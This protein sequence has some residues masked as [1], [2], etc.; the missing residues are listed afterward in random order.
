MIGRISEIFLSIQGEGIRAGEPM[1]FVRFT[2]CNLSCNYCDTPSCRHVIAGT[3]FTS[4]EVIA[5]IE[6]HL[7]KN[8]KVTTIAFTGGEPLL[9]SEFIAEII[10]YF[11]G[12]GIKSYIDTNGTLCEKFKLIANDVECVAMDIKLPSSSGGREFWGLH[13][14]FLNIATK[15]IFVKVVL[16]EK[17]TLA[18]FTKAVELVGEIDKR[19]PTV[20]Q[21][22]TPFNDINS[23]S[24][25]LLASF[26]KIAEEKL[27]NIY[28]VPQMH[29]KWGVK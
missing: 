23:I 21:P 20:L 27:K 4:E 6:S 12:K 11:K 2:G 25:E 19:I 17:T 24:P 3:I 18:E 9:H 22:S 14:Q 13:K 8:K 5:D 1:V 15:N 7:K 26:R 29:K 10:A 28:V 16:T